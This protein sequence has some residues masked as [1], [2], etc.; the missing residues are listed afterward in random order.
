[1][2]DY[3]LS[4]TG[5]A[6]RSASGLITARTYRS[7]RPPDQSYLSDGRAGLIDV[8]EPPIAAPD[9]S[10]LM[11]PAERPAPTSL[12]LIAVGSSPGAVGPGSANG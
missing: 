8:C 11:E 7:V 9:G 12:V 5:I 10:S 2:D 6:E 1:M 4:P 3:L